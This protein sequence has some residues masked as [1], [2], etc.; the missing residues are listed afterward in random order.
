MILGTVFLAL[1]AAVLIEAT[2]LWWLDRRAT[3]REAAFWEELRADAL[4]GY[5]RVFDWELECKEFGCH[6]ERP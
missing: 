5:G 3:R 6:E 2:M 4:A 1:A